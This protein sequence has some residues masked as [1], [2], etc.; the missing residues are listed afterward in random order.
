MG[1]SLN[2]PII[3]NFWGVAGN[4]RDD[5]M[6]IS[7]RCFISQ[8]AYCALA[9]GGAA[10]CSSDTSEARLLEIGTPDAFPI[11][12]TE[13]PLLRVAIVKN[14]AAN[15]GYQFSAV[16]LVCPHQGCAVRP[17]QTGFRCPC[18]GAEFSSD[19]TLIRGP[20]RKGLTWLQV[21]QEKDGLLYVN[22]SNPV[23]PT[24]KLV[25]PR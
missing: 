3:G 7:R 17:S 5:T 1:V 25:L 13:L 10:A 9:I 16:S 15:G 11:G 19:G 20:A 4:M 6:Y 24:W 12:R 2:K 23:E 14:S 22:F 18:H 8:C 21:Q